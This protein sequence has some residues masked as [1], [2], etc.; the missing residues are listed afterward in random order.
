[1][2]TT[3]CTVLSVLNPCSLQPP[4]RRVIGRELATVWPSVSVTP[5]TSYACTASGPYRLGLR[6]TAHRSRTLDDGKAGYVLPGPD[7]AEP[8]GRVIARSRGALRHELA[9]E[10][11]LWDD[12]E[13]LNL[14]RQKT[15][16]QTG[17]F[18]M[19]RFR[20]SD[21]S[22]VMVAEIHTAVPPERNPQRGR[23]HRGCPT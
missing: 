14:D 15:K 13:L 4:G 10:V 2:F 3:L 5:A 17:Q 6:S 11:S 9:N 22:S 21:H 12:R 16:R 1:M 18:R 19:P 23:P 8:I 7:P 20:Q